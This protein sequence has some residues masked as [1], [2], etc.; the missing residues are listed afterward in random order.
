[1]PLNRT[2]AG[3]GKAEPRVRVNAAL[4][5]DTE[6]DIRIKNLRLLLENVCSALAQESFAGQP[7][8]LDVANDLCLKIRAT[9]NMFRVGKLLSEP[10][11]SS[12]LRSVQASLNDLENLIASNFG[13]DMT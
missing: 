1:M 5:P 7:Q 2:V 3:H 8:A 9:E 4:A 12:V 13:V 11:R 10:A 6:L